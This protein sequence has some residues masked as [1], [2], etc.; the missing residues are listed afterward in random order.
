M[1]FIKPSTSAKLTLIL[2]IELRLM[3]HIELRFTGI[4]RLRAKN[5]VKYQ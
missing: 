1:V 3:V 5:L 4:F 2:R